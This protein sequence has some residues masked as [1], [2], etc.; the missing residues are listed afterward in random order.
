[1]VD[2]VYYESKAEAHAR[3]L[4]KFRTKP[5]VLRNMTITVSGM[6]D[7]FRVRLDAPRTTRSCS[8]RCAPDRT[9]C[10]CGVG[11]AWTASR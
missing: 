10:P 6:A 1:M 11:H 5:E 7:D 3:M 9:G 8:G 2:R 4:E